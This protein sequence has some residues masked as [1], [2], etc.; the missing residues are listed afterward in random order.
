M[1]IELPA[2]LRGV[3][4]RA[5]VHWPEADEDAMLRAAAAWRAAAGSVE[6]L[7]RDADF[8]A[9][10]ALDS[11]EGETRTAAHR[12][13]NGAVDGDSGALPTSSRE[14]SAAADRLEHAAHHVGEAKVRI[15]R[16]LVT[17]AKRTDAAESAAASGDTRAVAGVRTM[18]D[19]AAANIA[20]VNR[21]LADDVVAGSGAGTGST[22]PNTVEQV[23]DRSGQALEGASPD[24]VSRADAVVGETASRTEAT[25]DDTAD[26]TSQRA[27]ATF[28]SL[29]GPDDVSDRGRSS[30]PSIGERLS[31]IAGEAPAGG[32][33]AHRVPDATSTGPVTGEVIAAADRPAGADSEIGTGPVPVPETPPPAGQPVDVAPSAHDPRTDPQGV[34]QAWASPQAA[35]PGAGASGYPGAQQPPPAPNHAPVAGQGGY[36]PAGQQA[37]NQTPRADHSRPP[38]HAA[39]YG[40]NQARPA[41]GSTAR[42]PAGGGGPVYPGARPDPAS[43]ARPGHP[44]HGSVA[45]PGAVGRMRP[46]PGTAPGSGFPPGAAQQPSQHVEG[47]PLRGSERDGA[48]VAFVLHQFPIGHLPVA[49]DKPSRQWS[50]IPRAEPEEP[51]YPPN[52]HPRCELVEDADTNSSTRRS[53]NAGASPG[54]DIPGELLD[55]YEPLGSES[56]LSEGQWDQRYLVRAASD[57]DRAD[58]DWPAPYGHPENGVAPAEPVV[59]EPD[60]HVDRIG[61]GTGRVLCVPDTAFAKRSLPPEHRHRT[62]RSFRVRR[63][64]PVWQTISVSW[65]GQPGGGVRYRTTHPVD[66][67]LALGMVDDLDAAANTSDAEETVRIRPEIAEQRPATG[68]SADDAAETNREG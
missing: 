42:P 31:G 20:E 66:E 15:V 19:G 67:L 3:A 28:D 36:P 13:W 53:P 32:I 61:G 48:V 51:C 26:S 40:A 46:Q 55:G 4:Q 18:I 45:Q 17:L 43:G 27:G 59:L 34:Q 2:E 38:A 56:D 52:D 58:Y 63:P 14:C 29:D 1:G 24:V 44:P 65:F 30:A 5:G 39:G 60:S 68:A 9:Q 25:V 11:M 6:R 23:V 62:Y 10:G 37:A 54:G 41:P 50:V 49:A 12:E 16:E 57:N 33:D 21:N 8:S 64:L 22:Q 35:A 7:A 47:R